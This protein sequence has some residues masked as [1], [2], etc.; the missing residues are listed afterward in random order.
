M[1][2]QPFGSTGEIRAW[3]CCPTAIVSRA[4][5]SLLIPEIF[6]LK[7]IIQGDEHI[8]IL[9]RMASGI[10]SLPLNPS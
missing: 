9:D 10:L 7:L 3:L 1:V 5:Q 2:K 4:S 6:A 8:W